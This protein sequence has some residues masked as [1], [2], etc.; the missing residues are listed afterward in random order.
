MFFAGYCWRVW[1]ENRI[2]YTCSKSWLSVTSFW[3]LDR[4]ISCRKCCAMLPLKLMG[5][6]SEA[7]IHLACC[8]SFAENRQKY[9]NPMEN[10]IIRPGF[11]S[12]SL[13]FAKIPSPR[14][15]RRVISAQRQPVSF[16]WFLTCVSVCATL[17]A[18]IAC[19]RWAPLPIRLASSRQSFYG[20]TQLRSSCLCF[21]VILAAIPSLDS[22]FRACV[23]T[24]SSFVGLARVNGPRR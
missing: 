22:I 10:F 5:L 16:T 23:R 8:V 9:Q 4:L 12:T 17:L 20:N 24:R 2:G 18:G 19:S 14:R 6:F 13:H 7:K 1:F 11:P 3:Q 21:V 15:A